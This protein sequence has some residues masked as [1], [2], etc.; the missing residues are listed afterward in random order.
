[1]DNKKK[2]YFDVAHHV[3][4][5]KDIFVNFYMVQG[6]ES[7]AWFLVDAGLVT[8]Y[9]KVLKMAEQLF[10]QAPPKA[11]MLTHGHFDHIGSVIRLAEKWDVPVFAHELELPYLTGKSSYPP[12]DPSVGGGM[13]ARMA[14][15][16]PDDPID[17]SERVMPLSSD[18]AVLPDF[19]E[20]SFMHTPGHAPGHISLWREKDKLLIAGD[21]LVTTRQESLTSVILQT[22]VISGPPK[23]F[24]CDWQKAESS[25]RMLVNLEPAIVASGHGKPM[26]G[27]EMKSELESLRDNFSEIALPDQGRYVSEPAITDQNGI[28]SIPPK[29]PR[30]HATFITVG[31]LLGAAVLGYACASGLKRKNAFL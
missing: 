6:E 18:D 23:Y 19:P 5:Q 27:E 1:M 10:G 15:L 2:D 4:G 28:I 14:D 13:M 31:I 25:V 20:W 11:I 29:L 22:Q 8:S 26:Q 7:D 30:S 12:A 21:A 3:W 17:L 16:Y 24:T 9:G